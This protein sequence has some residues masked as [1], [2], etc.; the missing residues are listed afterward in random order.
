MRSVIEECKRDTFE[1]LQ[2]E[3]NINHPGKKKLK[4][5]FLCKNFNLMF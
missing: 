2:K 4:T 3:E 1:E 5:N